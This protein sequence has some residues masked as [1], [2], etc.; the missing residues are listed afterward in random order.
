MRRPTVA[1]QLLAALAQTALLAAP[2]AAA[3]GI[4]REALQRALGASVYLKVELVYQGQPISGSGS[5][6]FIHPDGFILTNQHVVSERFSAVVFGERREIPAAIIDITAVISSG[7][8]EERELPARVVARDRERDLALL[9][10]DWHPATW[11]DPTAFGEVKLVD[12]VWM[13]G[14]PFGGALAVDRSQPSPASGP[15]PE[16]TISSGMV[17]SLRRDDQGVLKAIQTD[18]ALNPGNSGGPMFDQQ[19]QLA[20]V[21][22]AGVPGASGLGFAIPPNRIREFVERQAAEVVFAPATVLDPPRPIQL[23]IRPVLVDALGLAGEVRLEGDDIPPQVVA[24]AADGRGGLAA[25]I[26]FPERIA[27]RARPAQYAATVT[28]RQPGSRPEVVRRFRLDAVSAELA[29]LSSGQA[30]GQ[31]LE[32]RQLL[33]NDMSIADYARARQKVGGGTTLREVAGSTSLPASGD[34]PV[35]V[36]DAAVS[37][38]RAST[39]AASRYRLVTDPQLRRSLEELDRV[40]AQVK[41]LEAERRT[42]A[43]TYRDRPTVYA[44]TTRDLDRRIH[45]RQRR[46]SELA[47]AA[48]AAGVLVCRDGTYFPASLPREQFPCP[49]W[50][51]PSSW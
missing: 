26:P 48:R 45:D 39:A 23:T 16:V 36:D 32:D 46:V 1:P 38:G 44:E 51:S 22:F 21:I 5:G 8:P 12:P 40:K 37:A 2:L 42:A 29:A 41:D 31:M 18:A 34:G 25:T 4:P 30:A 11:V 50:Q 33:A 27:G 6:F 3:E 10:V 19:G 24:L 28:L 17:T 49:T 14:Y 13:V 20:G 15:N 47:D 7:S 9:K 43:E 35:V